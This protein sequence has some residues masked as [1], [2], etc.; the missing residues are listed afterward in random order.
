MMYIKICF[1]TFISFYIILYF[2]TII[3]FVNNFNIDIYTKYV[4]KKAS[5]FSQD[6]KKIKSS[7][8]LFSLGLPEVIA[9][10][11]RKNK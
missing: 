11:G 8:P 10:L 4:H 3:T 5:T 7:L 6:K 2:Y 9:R 1:N